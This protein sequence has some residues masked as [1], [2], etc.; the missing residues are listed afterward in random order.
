MKSLA[1]LLQ[2]TSDSELAFLK[3]P[4]A[5]SGEFQILYCTL[6]KTR[7]ILFFIRVQISNADLVLKNGDKEQA[8]AI[9]RQI[10]PEQRYV[11]SANICW[12]PEAFGDNGTI[13]HL[14]LERARDGG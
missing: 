2:V 4:I 6:L 1:C 14:S 12:V 7:G 9:L 13:W 3:K 5:Q 10:T 8:L 11:Y